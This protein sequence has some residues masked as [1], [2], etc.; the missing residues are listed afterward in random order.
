[1]S[2]SDNLLNYLYLRHYLRLVKAYRAHSLSGITLVQLNTHC[3]KLLLTTLNPLYQ[4]IQF[5]LIRH[6]ERSPVSLVSRSILLSF[7]RSAPLLLLLFLDNGYLRE[8]SSRLLRSLKSLGY[9]LD[10][11]LD[12]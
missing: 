7:L 4:I 6:P 3:R 12:D 10:V 8:S 1:M 5:L 2:Q 9:L 11:L